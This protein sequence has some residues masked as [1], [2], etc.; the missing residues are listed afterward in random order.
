MPILKVGC[1]WVSLA[2]ISAATAHA[3]V[4]LEDLTWTELRDAVASGSTTVIIPI[5]GTEQNGPAMALGKHN[6]RVKILAGKIAEKLGH[7]I[8][9]P[10]ISYVPEGSIEPATA[11]MKFPG[12]LT[13]P[14]SVFNQVLDS[15]ANSLKHAGFK[16]V[17]F[18][19]D[20]GSY[21][22]DESLVAGKLNKQWAGQGARAYAAIEYYALTQGA[23][24]DALIAKGHPK[25]E[26]GTHAA[27]ADTSLQLAVAPE[28]VRQ[29][30]INNGP[31]LGTPD[32][33]YG[34]DPRHASAELGQ[35]GVDLI[36]DGTVTALSKF[37]AKK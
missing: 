14:D 7:T 20:H 18:V 27:L 30:K 12:T 8:V 34:G 37:I 33:V 5:G 21:Q 19:G 22:S 17:V 36:V 11:H 15:A 9:A 24:V 10:V 2:I 1:V 23:Y 16:N 28:M 25:S 26:I 13:I 3:S 35:M 32:G 6:V 4:Y 31:Q 29:D